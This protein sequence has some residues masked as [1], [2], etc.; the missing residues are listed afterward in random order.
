MFHIQKLF[1]TQDHSAKSN[2]LYEVAQVQIA[3]KVS[4]NAAIYWV[5]LIQYGEMEHVLILYINLGISLDTK[6]DH[7]CVL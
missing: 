2:I 7:F 1:L 6:T 4:R 5:C 3:H